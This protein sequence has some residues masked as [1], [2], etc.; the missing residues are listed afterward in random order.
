MRI[1]DEEFKSFLIN[2]EKILLDYN[3]LI[4]N[5]LCVYYEITDVVKEYKK[6]L[7]N[8]QKPSKWKQ[9][10]IVEFLQ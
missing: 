2:V 8:K 5:K 9:T 4:N 6:K 3:T 10:Q 1:N 7:E